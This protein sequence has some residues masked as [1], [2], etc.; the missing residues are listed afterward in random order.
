VNAMTPLLL[1]LLLGIYLSATFAVL[2]W[3]RGRF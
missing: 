1:A 3:M 2:R